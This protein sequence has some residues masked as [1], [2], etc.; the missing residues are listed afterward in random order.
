[1]TKEAWAKIPPE[2]RR[3]RALQARRTSALKIITERMG[4]LSEE[5]KDRIFDALYPDDDA[6]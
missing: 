4:E 3:R 2:E 1:M 5:E 6:A